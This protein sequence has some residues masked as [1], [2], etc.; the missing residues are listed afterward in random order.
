MR[1]NGTLQYET[2]AAGGFDDYGEPIA[3]TAAWSDPLPCRITA[4]SDNRRGSYDGGEFRTAS[5]SV[6]VE[7]ADFPHHTV[8]LTRLGEPMGDYRVM[9]AEPLAAVG[10]TRITV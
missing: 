7:L 10:R 5:F 1:T 8:R 2:V 3:A 6:L 4:N 9:S